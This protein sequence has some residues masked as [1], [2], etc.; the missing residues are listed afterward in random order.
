M[1]S[2][3]RIGLILVWAA[4]FSTACREASNGG[5]GGAGAGNLGGEGGQGGEPAAGGA[6]ASG[7]G[8]NSGGAGGAP[9]PSCTQAREDAL[10][11]IDS[12]SD[13]GVTVLEQVGDVVTLFVDASAGGV[14]EQASNPWIYLDLA[15]RA[16]VDVTDVTADASTTWDLAFKRPVVRSN[17]G[18]GGLAGQGGTIRVPKAFDAVS[19]ADASA[20]FETES[21]FDQDCSL[22]T[23]QAGAIATTF[24]GWYDYV[25]MKVLP[26]AGTWLIRSGDGASVFKL[27]IVDYYANPDGSSGMAGG[28]YLMRVADVTP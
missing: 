19:T 12:V 23:D 28:R 15:T 2:R 18:D 1:R 9:S 11:P 27:E 6:A 21:W 10:G 25:E 3:L 24:D 7:G 26:A 20:P 13:G 8:T 16:R 5:A 4:G 22:F 14:Q 17:S